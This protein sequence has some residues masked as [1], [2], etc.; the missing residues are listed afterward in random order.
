MSFK[1]KLGVEEMSIKVEHRQN[2]NRRSGGK[3]FI[4]QRLDATVSTWRLCASLRTNCIRIGIRFHNRSLRRCSAYLHV[5]IRGTLKRRNIDL[6][7]VR[8]ASAHRQT[9]MAISQ[10]SCLTNFVLE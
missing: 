9:V 5:E 8:M 2:V 6:K 10:K 7:R 3:A 4:C 1:P